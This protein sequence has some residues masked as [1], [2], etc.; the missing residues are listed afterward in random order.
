MSQRVGT[1]DFDEAVL[2]SKVP[3]L[4]DFYSDTCVPCKR[5]ASRLAKLEA[6]LGSALLVAKVNVEYDLPLAERYKVVASPTLLLF[7]DSR[8]IDRHQGVMAP[9]ELK[10]FVEKAL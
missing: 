9:E 3:V 5:L 8:E 10:D 6:E 4:V 2:G 7:K 1:D